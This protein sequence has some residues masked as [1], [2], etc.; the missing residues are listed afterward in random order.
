V[1]IAALMINSGA[2]FRF[3]LGE[4][5]DYS[6]I[7]DAQVRFS[8]SPPSDREFENWRKTNR[9]ILLRGY[10]DKLSLLA[11]EDALNTN[12][13]CVKT[14]ANTYGLISF[15]KHPVSDN[16]ERYAIFIAGIDLCATLTVTGKFFDLDFS[17]RPFGGVVKINRVR[18]RQWRWFE[19]PHFGELDPDPEEYWV[20]PPYSAD[21]LLARLNG[22]RRELIE[23]LSA[24]GNTLTMAKIQDLFKR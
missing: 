3:R 20:T 23:R 15:A 24:D 1:N 12:T 22:N 10:P 4:D 7:R 13:S 6:T 16:D 14:E 19:E 8:D 9:E 5:I 18:R 21:A 11:I 17:Q 2:I